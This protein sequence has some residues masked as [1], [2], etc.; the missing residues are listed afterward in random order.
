MMTK[1][2]MTTQ[3]VAEM[4]EKM[5]PQINNYTFL[6]GLMKIGDNYAIS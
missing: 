4:A 1:L 3:K 6:K 2:K 5:I